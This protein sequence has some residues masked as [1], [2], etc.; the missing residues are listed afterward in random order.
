VDE[1]RRKGDFAVG[2]I[3]PLSAWRSKLSFERRERALFQ[4]AQALRKL[5][6][7]RSPALNGAG[8]NEMAQLQ[9]DTEIQRPRSSDQD[10]HLAGI[11]R[12]FQ[13]HKAKF[14]PL[15]AESFSEADLA[16]E[17]CPIYT[18]G[19]CLCSHSFHGASFEV[20]PVGLFQ[21]KDYKQQ[22]M[23]CEPDSHLLFDSGDGRKRLIP[24]RKGQHN[25]VAHLEPSAGRALFTGC[26]LL[27]FEVADMEIGRSN[28]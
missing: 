23:D 26:R 11:R 3:F 25:C 6:P 5:L 8:D 19:D 10:P 20:I 21:E 24:G 7:M 22:A 27:L 4:H 16:H 12:K 15:P 9:H 13:P 17:V 1:L 28:S 14:C 2:S 18:Q